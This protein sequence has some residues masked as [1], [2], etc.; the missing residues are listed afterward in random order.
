M[1]EAVSIVIPNLH[2]PV[3]NRVL[4]TL[5]SQSWYP[6][7]FEVI[8]V[9]LDRYGLVTEDASVRFLRTDGPASPAKARNLGWRAARHDAIVFL[10]A[11]CVP[12]PDW[13]HNL[14]SFASQQTKVG[15]VSCG[16]DCE[17][18]SFWTICDQVASF[19]EHS[20]FNPA[21]RAAKLA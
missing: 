10:D 19:H 3:I 13:L 20:L 6:V 14:I 15:A 16:I 5:K 17:S 8:V 4:A 11:D 7:A 9:G 2:S 18:R 12:R 1:I 21:R